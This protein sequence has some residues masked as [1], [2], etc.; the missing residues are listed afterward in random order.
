MEPPTRPRPWFWRRPQEPM[1][2]HE[3]GPPR[4]HRKEGQCLPRR[5][6]PLGEAD[7]GREK[8]SRTCRGPV[9]GVQGVLQWA[10]EPGGTH[11]TL[12]GA[13]HR[14]TPMS[15]NSARRGHLGKCITL[16]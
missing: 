3:E 5:G 14:V 1:W 6:H 12:V 4:V 11:M 7:E 16:S 2:A 9:P 10:A 13:T 15:S 8:P